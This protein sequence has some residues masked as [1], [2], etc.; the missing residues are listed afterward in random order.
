MAKERKA[1]KC[2]TPEC[3]RKVLNRGVCRHCYR[4]FYELVR[5]K[6]MTVT[7]DVVTWLL[8]EQ[9]GRVLPA[10]YKPNS[11]R[12]AIRSIAPLLADTNT[13]S[14]AMEGQAS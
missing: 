10:H 9:Q 12:P 2:L 14:A 5:S 4:D 13:D 7:G 11:K 1:Q 3:G 8:L 6:A